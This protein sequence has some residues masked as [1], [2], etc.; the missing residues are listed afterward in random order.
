MNGRCPRHS[1]MHEATRRPSPSVRGYDK[2]YQ[3]DRAALLA[4]RPLCE[5]QLPGCTVWATTADHPVALAAGG[6]FRQA[7]V[8][9]C[10]HCNSTKGAR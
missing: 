1:A 8:P 7:L 2:T 4:E 9:A 3:R 10:A 5:L 6:S